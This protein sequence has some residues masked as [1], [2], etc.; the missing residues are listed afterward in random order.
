MKVLFICYGNVAR[1][2]MAEAYYNKYTN[3]NNAQ[4]AGVGYGIKGRYTHPASDVVK[5]MLEEDI[6]VS[7]KEVKAI[8]REMIDKADKIIV[9]CDLDDCPRF[10]LESG[11][12][13]HIL[14]P[15]P[16]GISIDYTRA[17]RDEI[18]SLVLDLIHSN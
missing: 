8:T 13:E 5:V 15:D 2:Q 4:S 7:K 16:F 17:V 6:D 18:K 14:V 9:M 11:K 12:V 10:L 3:S 1:S